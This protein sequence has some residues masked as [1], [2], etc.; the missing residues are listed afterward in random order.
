MIKDYFFSKVFKPKVQKVK[1]CF[2]YRV[3]VHFDNKGLDL[4]KL[5]SIFNDPEVVEAFPAS[6]NENAFPTVI[7]SLNQPFRSKLLN[8][9]DTVAI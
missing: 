2:K 7:H 9:K 5:S 4:I 1:K 3:R 6:D 8:H